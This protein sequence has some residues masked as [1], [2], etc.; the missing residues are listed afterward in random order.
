MHTVDLYD[1]SRATTVPSVRKSDVAEIELPLPPLAEQRRIVEAIETQFTRLE[2]GVAGLEQV[3]AKLRRYRTAVL[4]AACEGRL[5]PQNPGDEP[6]ANLLARI[7]TER[8][9][10]WDGRG[11]YK[12][13]A[14]ISPAAISPPTNSPRRGE[15]QTQTASSPAG[16]SASPP[17][18]ASASSPAG[19]SAP[20]PGGGDRGGRLP[21]LPVGWVW[22]SLDQLLREPLRNGHSAKASKTDD[23]VR[24]L[25]LTAVTL[26][27]FSV[28]NTKLTGADP[29]KVEDL[30]IQPGDI[31]IERSNTPELVGTAQLYRGQPNFAIFPDLLI[32]ARITKKILNTYVEIILKED[33]TRAYFK[34]S[35]QGISGTMPKISQPIIENL[36]IP[37]PPL[38]EQRRIVAEVERRLSV[39]AEVEAAIE[40]NLRRATR[41]RQ[42]ILKKAFAG[43]LV[44]QNPA[45]E[46]AS[47]LLARIKSARGK[48]VV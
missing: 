39:V 41:L 5:V 9:Q 42:A 26:G 7:L 17:A 8:R 16:A 13:P 29:T 43:Q 38:A 33:K 45:D 19:A 24:T 15:N 36:I 21:Q 23:G 44:R 4:K 18:D 14:A 3:R 46:P 20:P 10:Q 2:A 40:A 6:A 32:R 11:K 22:A 12:E 31:F 25:T 37:L 47:A 28:T 48:S 30:W 35:A 27:D 34:R 1:L